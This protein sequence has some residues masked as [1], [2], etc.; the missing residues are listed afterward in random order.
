[1][2]IGSIALL[3]TVLASTSPVMPV[4]VG[5]ALTLPAQ[6]HAVRIETG[7]GRSPAWLLAIQQE[8]VEGR[9]L[10]L[11]RSD[12]E[13]RSFH[14]SAPIQPDGSHADRADLIAVG[15]DVAL[16]YSWESP[17]LK[18]SSRHDVYFQWWRYQPD[19]HDWEP[20]PAVRIFNADDSTA[21]T[22][23]L[24]ARDS[25]GRLWVQAFRLDSDGG[26]TA[27]VSVSTDGGTSFQRQPNLGRVK[28]RGG[29]RLLSVG[30]QLVFLYAMH[31]G[32]EPTRMRI[33]RD[34]DPVETWGAVKTA[35]SEGIYHGAA[36][37]A[38]ADGH[39]GMH[40]VYKDEMERLYYRHFDGASFGSRTLL[41]SSRDWAMQAAITRVGETLY[42]FYNVMRSPHDAYAIHVRTLRNGQFS[43]PV[44]LDSKSTYK[45]YP[46]ALETLPEGMDEVPCFFGEAPDDNSRGNLVR[47]K[48]DVPGGGSDDAP[49]SEPSEDIPPPGRE[50]FREGFSRGSSR[51]LGSDWSLSGLWLADGRR[52]VSDLD[53]PDGN[54]QALASPSRCRD[55]QVEAWLQA[56][57]ADEAGVVLRAQGD[58]SYALVYLPSGRIQIRRYRNGAHT[59]LGEASSGQSSAWEG[60][61][62]TLAAWGTGPVRLAASVNGQLRL[63]VTD[64][65]PAAP[66]T[67][68][69]AGLLTPIAGVWF[70]DFLVR[71][72]TVP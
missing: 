31:D 48:L 16:V 40:L 21:Y 1:M 23:A 6:R 29:G 33:R 44:V 59:V 28:R 32:F 13:G 20:E 54:N 38:A 26:S 9:G 52:A 43:D 63:V 41:E 11:Y 7:G 2:I 72:L 68:G 15:R 35:F 61:R 27:V 37:S 24:L 14:F 55:C 66:R 12:D 70:D 36:L 3:A 45:G 50:L 57:A 69:L 46:N 51:G 58:A 8:G 25:R 18:A 64:A 67:P 42:V 53:N 56:F 17:S 4:R 62:F 22:R 5:N 49:P 60:A 39:G 47:V 30:S 10:S 71:E 34:G 19:T 65:S